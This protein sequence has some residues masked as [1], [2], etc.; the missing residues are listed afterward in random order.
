MD[1]G[2]S[3]STAG[4]PGSAEAP[5]GR[6]TRLTPELAAARARQAEDRLAVGSLRF[7][8]TVAVPALLLVLVAVGNLVGVLPLGHDSLEPSG[9]WRTSLMVLV[10]LA[11]CMQLVSCLLALEFWAIDERQ[12][13]DRAGRGRVAAVRLFRLLIAIAVPVAVLAGLTGPHS[14]GLTVVV[15]AV[16]E[17]GA[18]VAI[19]VVWL[20]VRDSGADGA[21]AAAAVPPNATDP[22]TE[23]KAAEQERTLRAIGASGGGIRAAAFVLGGYQALQ[24]HASDL[25]ISRGPEPHVFAVSGGSYTAAA[26]A[27]RRAFRLEDGAPRATASAWDGVYTM[28]SPELERLR[29]HTRYLFEPVR[30]TRDGVVSLL[31]GAFVNLA[32]VAVALRL[33]AWIGVQLAIST[34]FVQLSSKRTTGGHLAPQVTALTLARGWNGADWLIMLAV[35]ILCVVAVAALTVYGWRGSTALDAGATGTAA[36]TAMRRLGRSGAW[37]STLVAVAGVWLVVLLG[38]PAITWGIAS[39]TSSNQ[40]NATAASALKGLG[41]GTEGTCLEA[42]VKHVV[43]ASETATDEA[44]VSPGEKREVTTGACGTT[45]DVART[46]DPDT[47]APSKAADDRQQVASAASDLFASNQ[48]VR[49]IAGVGV[50][51]AAVFA[52]LRRGP[53]PEVAVGAKWYTR[54]K[55]TLLTWVP[56]LLVAGLGLYAL[57]AFG[58]RLLLGMDTAYLVWAAALTIAGFLLAYMLDANGTSMHGFYRSRLSDAFAVGVDE[59]GSHADELPSQVIYRFSD[60]GKALDPPRLHIVTTLNSQRPN[61]AP[62]MRGGFPMVFG[63]NAVELHREERCSVRVPAYDY[64]EFAGPG[65]VS[66]MATVATSGAA[67]SPLMGRYANQMKPYRLLLTLFNLRVGTW[68]RN[69]LHL[70]S[71][72]LTPGGWKR[73]FWMTSRP[74]LAQVMAEA[75]GSSSSADGRWIYLSD[76][77][78]LDNTGLVEC[79]RHC[80]GLPG[81]ILALD[82]SNDPPGAWSAV[83]DAIGVIRADLDIDLVQVPLNNPGNGV[84]EVR[85]PWARRYQ[86]SDLDVLVVKAVRPPTDGDAEVDWFAML[87]PNVRSFLLTHQDFPRSSTARQ[88]FGDLEFEAYRGFGYAT[89]VK[90]LQVAGWAT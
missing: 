64:E 61:E 4:S 40:P 76:G 31:A 88:R 63:P 8:V 73:V 1:S 84:A 71:V 27:M 72:D 25:N 20:A 68:V 48:I 44:R 51:V 81:R 35:P 46:V 62:T 5:T 57:F 67:I 90:A 29:R 56:L 58:Y 60:V 80:A 24:A 28:A 6:R 30:F 32:L 69:P 7:G 2:W 54:L 55:R 70:G 39:M 19:V 11:V 3:E 21:P 34:G 13:R 41:F 9:H 52:L 42:F 77:G 85:L 89:T 87:P 37:R 26:L 82:A 43:D 86:G 14:W 23:L 33:L 16:A 47:G 17:G 38:L 49:Q 53:S 36:D 65:R 83:G 74:G 15:T 66:I 79:V 59:A 78:H 10:L 50:A 75:H 22:F 45:V 18:L 12:G